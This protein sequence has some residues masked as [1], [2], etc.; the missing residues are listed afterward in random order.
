MQKVSS[1]SG[2]S[3]GARASSDVDDR[4]TLA[5]RVNIPNVIQESVLNGFK[6]PIFDP[7]DWDSISNTNPSLVG[8]KSAAFNPV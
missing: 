7:P 6:A 1:N 2:F 3:L 8:R 4:P 5:T